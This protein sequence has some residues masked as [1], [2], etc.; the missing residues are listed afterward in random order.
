MATADVWRPPNGAHDVSVG[1]VLQAALDALDSGTAH[2]GTSTEYYSFRYNFKPESVDASKPGRIDN[3]EP[4][5]DGQVGFKLEQSST[6]GEDRHTFAGIQSP[7]KDFE[8]VLIYDEATGDFTLEK[9]ESWIDLKY[10][11][12][13]SFMNGTGRTLSPLDDSPTSKA[14]LSSPSPPTPRQQESEVVQTVQPDVD[15]V[16]DIVEAKPPPPAVAKPKPRARA[17]PALPLNGTNAGT[18]AK[19]KRPREEVPARNPP[20][21][22]RP[23]KKQASPHRVAPPPPRAPAPLSLPSRAPTPPPVRQSSPDR[24]APLPGTQIHFESD[25]EEEPPL[26]LMRDVLTVDEE[27][28]LLVPPIRA[29]F[30][31]GLEEDQGIDAMFDDLDEGDEDG[32]GEDDDGDGEMEEDENGAGEM[33]VDGE[34]EGDEDEDDED[35]DFGLDLQE[36]LN[37]PVAPKVPMSLSEFAGGGEQYYEESDEDSEDES[38]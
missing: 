3:I 14:T 9:V 23:T 33:E 30:S 29:P 15:L 18:K 4:K 20:P 19:G 2:S 25:E 24:F 26:P 8:C 32:I 31:K 1:P 27:P 37:E 13:A 38:E 16:L 22:T 17:P 21:S 10:D 7:A 36:A 34:V 35:E 11:R 6:A 12:A 28:P 5:T